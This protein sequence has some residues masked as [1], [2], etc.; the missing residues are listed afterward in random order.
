MR[1]IKFVGAALLALGLAGCN[2]ALPPG[3]M[4][5]PGPGAY[6]PPPPPVYTPPP[7]RCYF[8]D[9][10]YGTERICRRPSYY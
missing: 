2:T 5:Q 1:A 8:R 4:V 9:G 7:A 3:T 6:Y 10:P